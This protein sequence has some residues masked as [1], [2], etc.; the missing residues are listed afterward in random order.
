MI[1][2]TDN[3]STVFIGLLTGLVIIGIGYIIRAILS[4]ISNIADGFGII[5]QVSGIFGMFVLTVGSLSQYVIHK[6]KKIQE[7]EIKTL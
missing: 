2:L 7:Y 4:P 5:L 1:K 6:H 3:Q